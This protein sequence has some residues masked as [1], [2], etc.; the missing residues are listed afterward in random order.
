MVKK[1][2]MI[3]HCTNENSGDYI[4]LFRIGTKNNFDHVVLRV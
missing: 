1:N 3:K 4:E 2:I